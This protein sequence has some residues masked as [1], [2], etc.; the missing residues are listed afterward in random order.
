MA[1]RSLLSRCPSYLIH[2]L[3]GEIIAERLAVIKLVKKSPAV[4]E[5]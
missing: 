3:H 1:K 5:P 2:H 4:M